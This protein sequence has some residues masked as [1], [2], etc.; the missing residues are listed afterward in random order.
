MDSSTFTSIIND[1]DYDYVICFEFFD[2]SEDSGKFLNVLSAYLND[3]PS[4]VKTYNEPWFKKTEIKQD[5]RRKAKQ[6]VSFAKA[7][8]NSQNIAFIIAENGKNMSKYVADII[9]YTSDEG[10]KSFNPPAKPCNVT[11][12]EVSDT[13]IMLSWDKP[14]TGTKDLLHYTVS[15]KKNSDQWQ[16]CTCMTKISGESTTCSLENLNSCTKYEIRVN[17]EAICGKSEVEEI[18][19][20]TQKKPEINGCICSRPG[21]PR[22]M[23]FLEK[24]KLTWEKPVAGADLVQSYTVHYYQANARHSKKVLAS[25]TSNEV[26]LDNL[27][28]SMSYKFTVIAHCELGNSEE[29]EESDT[30]TITQT[31]TICTAPGKPKAVNVLPKS[32]DLIWNEPAKHAYLIKYYSIVYNVLGSG[33]SKSINTE[34][35]STKLTIDS[36]YPNTTYT[37][38][39]SAHCELGVSEESE[40]SNPISTMP[41][42][43]LKLSKPQATTITNST[44]ALTWNLVGHKPVKRY[45]V[46]YRQVSHLQ[47]KWMIKEVPSTASSVVIDELLSKTQ[48][49]FKL[50]AYYECGTIEESEE[51]EPITTKPDTCILCPPSKPV[52]T[53]ITYNSVS[54]TWN[55]PKDLHQ[56]AIICYHVHYNVQN[57][58]EC[59]KIQT[60][61][62]SRAIAIKALS[63]GTPYIFKVYAQYALGMST[64]SENSDVIVTHDAIS[65]PPSKPTAQKIEMTSITLAWKPPQQYSELVKCYSI[66][67]AKKDNR[68]PVNWRIAPLS[69]L[70]TEAVIDQLQ[71]NTAYIFKI[72]ALCEMGQMESQESNVIT[73]GKEI[74]SKPG[75]PAATEKT[76][77]SVTLAWDKP[78]AN[79]N[80]VKYYS[81]NC[82]IEDESQKMSI[83]SQTSDSTTSTIIKKLMPNTVYTF[84]VTAVCDNGESEQS[85]QSDPITTLLAYT[86]LEKPKAAKITSTSVS[87][88]WGKV[89]VPNSS[90]KRYLVYYREIK[91]TETTWAVKETYDLMPETVITNLKPNSI[92]IF[93]VA[94]QYESGVLE[95][96]EESDPIRTESE[97]CSSPGKPVPLQV[98]HNS[99]SLKWDMPSEN[100][101]V[102]QHYCVYY[103]SQGNTSHINQVTTPDNSPHIVV[104]SLIPNTIYIFKVVAVCQHSSSI[105]SQESE[106]I[107][108]E[109]GVCSMPGTPKASQISQHTIHLVWDNPKCNPELNHC[110]LVH[111]C[112]LHHGKQ[113]PWRIITNNN[114][115]PEAMIDQ[116]Q[117][118]TSYM[119]KVV[120]QCE[121]GKI[122]SE[123]SKPITTEFEICSKPGKPHSSNVSYNT[124]HLNWEKPANHAHMVH[125]YEIHGKSH[126]KTQIIS[127]KLETQ[128]SSNNITVNSLLPATTYTFKVIA[129]CDSGYSETSD[130]SEPIT[131]RPQCCSRPGRPEV[132]EVT[133]QSIKIQWSPPYENKEL[134]KHY[135]V[136]A[137][138]KKHAGGSR[139]QKFNRHTA[140]SVPEFFMDNL[141][142]SSGYT[143][144]IVAQCTDATSEESEESELI[145]TKDSM[146][147]P[148]KPIALETNVTDIL[149]EWKKPEYYH[150]AVKQY[151]IAVA[152]RPISLE[153]DFNINWT[154]IAGTITKYRITKLTPNTTYQFR[155]IA[156]SLDGQ[157]V[158]S[159][160][161]DPIT[162]KKGISTPPGKPYQLDV[163]ENS[164]TLQWDEP[165]ENLAM[166]SKYRIGFYVV[167]N[168]RINWCWKTTDKTI[169]RIT[170]KNLQPNSTYIFKV[171]AQCEHGDSEESEESIPIKTK[172]VCT[173]PG[174]PYA[175]DRSNSTILLKWETPVLGKEHI[176]RYCIQYYIYSGQI[177]YQPVQELTHDSTTEFLIRNLKPNTN[178]RFCIIAECLSGD[179][180]EKSEESELISTEK[181]ACGQPGKPKAS[182]VTMDSITLTW[183]KPVE[184]AFLISRYRIL[185]HSH[186]DCNWMICTTTHDVTETV[187]IKPLQ[188]STEYRFKIQAECTNNTLSE[189]SQIS[190]KISTR[191]LKLIQKYLP[192]LQRIP[193]TGSILQFYTI[194]H[195]M[196]KEFTRVD[197]RIAKFTFGQSQAYRPEKVLMIIGA[198]GA[199]K[200]TLINGVVNYIF[201]VKWEDQERLKLVYD[202]AKGRSQ[203]E[204]QTEWITAYTFNWEEGFPFPYNLTIIDTP[205]FGDT[206]GL[207]RDKQLVSQI[208]DLFEL[209]VHNGGIDQLHGIG[210][211]T[212]ASLA[213][214]THTQRYIFDSILAVFGKDAAKNISIMAT[215]ADGADPPV[216]EAVK[217]AQVPYQSCFKFNNSALFSTARD[218]FSSMFWQMGVQ[219]LKQ[220]FDCLHTANATS[221]QLTREVL[222]ERY[223]LE[224][225]IAGIQPQLNMGLS[226]MEELRQEEMML[227]THEADIIRSKDFKYEIEITKQNKIDLET[228]EYVT[229]CLV[230]NC[231]CHY[232]C[233]IPA[234]Q[235]KYKCYAMN[236]QGDTSANCG[237]CPGMC[238]WE[239][240]CNNPYRFELYQ[241]SEVR[242]VDDLRKRYNQ[243]LEDKQQVE[244]MVAK[245]QNEV[246]GIFTNVQQNIQRISGCLKRLDEIALKPNP[247]SDVE[248]IDLLIESEKQEAKPGYKHRIKHLQEVRQQA[249]VVSKAPESLQHKEANTFWQ[250]ASNW[251]PHY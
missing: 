183:E 87:I 247:L 200:S 112:S 114:A 25:S 144:K 97:T 196:K 194:K 58:N 158:Q 31:F 22:A 82:S 215:F 134:V 139:V 108:T 125:H 13:T 7:N 227:K 159:P 48:Y 29:S 99:I 20:T 79:A 74:C 210:F 228:G 45:S 192:N 28:P 229:N 76:H 131:T 161:S 150:R 1:I 12:L 11:A 55:A 174:K 204:S 223:Q 137:Y 136:K 129:K 3:V 120:A 168:Q 37:F 205:G 33:I 119:F 176:K 14:K 248:Y 243:A 249:V 96:S 164:I 172:Q 212:Q 124:I 235:E 184:C 154:A 219:S 117:P 181:E 140:D 27:S 91:N 207:K 50:A 135:I 73:T 239:K 75:K 175:A 142:P 88:S 102:V 67:Y 177:N 128:D 224:T 77:D 179:F 61:D 103:Y 23:N 40:E 182:E 240:H 123:E 35:N 18:T 156:E 232:P 69:E 60:G 78:K 32:I 24:F 122:E 39:V 238:S 109:I 98:T 116:L 145:T 5:L 126:N 221:L 94:A 81:I 217:K 147:P 149:L 54:L 38:K 230:C 104:N 251:W 59:Y 85:E 68:S 19:V 47:G 202:E 165:K 143:F 72:A 46:Y 70:A 113:G 187:T 218:N 93:K 188:P 166:V 222:E 130:E 225:I 105:T 195:L 157:T 244:A 84:K 170:I 2:V 110:Y 193:S 21:K 132:S 86:N 189:E 43:S 190:D 151:N 111:Y 141:T 250:S 211:V 89:V 152:L 173:P 231:T 153:S 63:P 241:E 71:P 206:R 17:A 198:T 208:K 30:I 127:I 169:P 146:D 213:R 34:N 160:I 36:L 115:E 216:L 245:M 6:F 41:D 220:F 121:Y 133:H 52:P 107:K 234:D 66:H 26:L 162:T 167:S 233:Y 138:L 83:Y 186:H 178:Y 51:T 148:G 226:K 8:I 209:K 80:L 9:L 171:I 214:L 101:H 64:A 199:G 16:A 106:H 42:K 53:E 203:A 237:V 49:I 185:Y 163:S 201:G 90:I 56:F 100:P 44:I 92:Y 180:S 197:A 236:P 95:E 242:T 15:Y 62:A 57:T 10:S 4:S 118:G 65:S 246:H 191:A 155:V